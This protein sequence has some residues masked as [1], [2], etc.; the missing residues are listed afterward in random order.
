MSYPATAAVEHV[1]QAT[2]HIRSKRQTGTGFFV[3]RNILLTCAHV[4]DAGTERVQIRVQGRPPVPGTVLKRLPPPVGRDRASYPLPDLAFIGVDGNIDHPVAEIRSLLLHYGNNQDAS[5][6][7]FGFNRHAPEPDLGPDIVR[8]AVQGPSE[9]YV[10]AHAKVG[11]AP[12]MSGAPV[13][14]LS[15]GR[16]C[17][18]LKYYVPEQEAAWF[19]DALDLEKRLDAYRALLGR[20]EPR[21]P[22]LFLPEKHTP[23]WKM[24]VAQQT[25]A[26][27]LPYRARGKAKSGDHVDVL[28]SGGF[29]V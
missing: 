15:T 2:V 1:R 18:M 13:V 29:A 14:E 25:V 7:A 6:A 21:K 16:V 4:L 19:I 26:E 12:G 22:R 8:M 17:G 24:L 5:I 27:K 10:K 23:L 9:P 11:V 20:F 28:L 3:D